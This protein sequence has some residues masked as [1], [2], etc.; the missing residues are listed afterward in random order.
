MGTIT[1]EWLASV[2]F[3][4]RDPEQGQQW[5]HWKLTFNEP[6]DYGMY[7]E[8]T[9]PGWL[10]RDG[11]L[12]AGDTGWYVWL[13]RNSQFM[14]I[15]HMHTQA[16]MIALVEAL[17]GLPWE[18]TRMGNVQVKRSRPSPQDTK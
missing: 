3:K 14:H 10:N 17:S 11:D 7:I 15:R 2:G 18:P 12:I 4:Y 9:A 13:G 6:D 16:E 1:E 8:T 5:K